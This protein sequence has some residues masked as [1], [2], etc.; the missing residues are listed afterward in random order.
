[1]RR[2]WRH[3]EEALGRYAGAEYSGLL[4]DCGL[5]LNNL[6]FSE[7]DKNEIYQE[8]CIILYTY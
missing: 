3:Q 1:M 2:L 4:F 8:V 5:G 6:P 7:G